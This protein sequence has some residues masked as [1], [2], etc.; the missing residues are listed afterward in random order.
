[1]APD[2]H[3]MVSLRSFIDERK[4]YKLLGVLLGALTRKGRFSLSKNIELESKRYKE[5]KSVF[6]Y[7]P[8]EPILIRMESH[9]TAD[10]MERLFKDNYFDFDGR[11]K[12]KRENL[13]N[14]LCKV[15]SKDGIAADKGL[16]DSV[17][18]Y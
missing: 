4:D 16:L 17:I 1:M 15:F 9:D 2:R 10:V 11:N 5:I 3:A 6:G 14:L 12:P 18:N 7:A 13:L 8:N